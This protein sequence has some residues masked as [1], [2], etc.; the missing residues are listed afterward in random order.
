[1]KLSIIP[2]ILAAVSMILFVPTA[3]A[4]ETSSS[5]TPMMMGDVDVSMAPPIEG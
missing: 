5:T 1:M 4:E 2:I 3:S